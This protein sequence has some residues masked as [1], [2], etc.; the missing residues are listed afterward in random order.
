MS[1]LRKSSWNGCW[2]QICPSG[3]VVR[4][5]GRDG[6]PT[7]VVLDLEDVRQLV[8]DGMSDAGWAEWFRAELRETHEV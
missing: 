7:K 1:E 6:G 8:T 4:V 2:Y 3:V 5:H